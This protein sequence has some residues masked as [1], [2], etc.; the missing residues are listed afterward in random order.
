[1]RSFFR[2]LPLMGLSEFARV[3]LTDNSGSSDPSRHAEFWFVYFNS[4]PSLYAVLRQWFSVHTLTSRL[5]FTPALFRMVCSTAA[6]PQAVVLTMAG[7]QCFS[8]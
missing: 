6:S 2:P 1:M 5:A 7:P 8:A 3:F 4:P